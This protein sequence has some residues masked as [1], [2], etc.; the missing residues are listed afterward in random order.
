MKKHLLEIGCFFVFYDCLIFGY[1]VKYNV[2]WIMQNYNWKIKAINLNQIPLKDIFDEKNTYNMEKNVYFAPKKSD[3][4][5]EGTIQGIE[6]S[7]ERIN[8]AIKNGEKICVYADYDADG[9][10]SCAILLKT[11][12]CLGYKNITHYIPSRQTEGYGL[13]N[14]AVQKLSKDGVT[15]II[16]VDCGITSVQEIELANSLGVDVI[17]TDHHHCPEILPSAHCIINPHQKN[18]P[19]T[20]KNLC[21]AGI[22]YKLSDALLKKNGKETPNE[23]LELAGIATVTDIVELNGENRTIVKLALDFIKNGENIGVDALLKVAGIDRQSVNSR[24]IGFMIGPRINSAGRIAHADLALRLLIAENEQDALSFANELNQLNAKRQSFVEEVYND[25]VKKIN[26]EKAK[27][28]VIIT[29]SPEYH[30][31]VIGIAASKLVEKYGKIAV[32]L[33]EQSEIAVASL[34]SIEGFSIVDLLEHIRPITIKSGGHEMAGG[35]SVK[36]SDLSKIKDMIYKY[37]DKYYKTHNYKPTK[38]IDLITS[39]ENLTTENHDK[40]MRFEP[41]GA[42]NENFTLAVTDVNL[43]F[44]DFIGKDKNTFCA[45]LDDTNIKVI[46]FLAFEELK[47]LDTGKKLD[48]AF[49][50]NKNTFNNN[51][52]L[53]LMLEDVKYSEEVLQKDTEAFYKDVDT[54]L[55]NTA[56]IKKLIQEANEEDVK[57][58]AF[59]D[60]FLLQGK[61]AIFTCYFGEYKFIKKSLYLQ[62]IDKEK[63]EV[64]FLPFPIDLEEYENVVFCKYALSKIHFEDSQKLYKIKSGDFDVYKKRN[65]LRDNMKKIYSL[66]KKFGELDIKNVISNYKIELDELFA[67][68]KILKQCKL[69]DISYSKSYNIAVGKILSVNGKVDLQTV[70][71]YNIYENYFDNEI[72]G[73]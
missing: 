41:F 70:D 30:A 3:L 19:S 17:I 55:K 63:A 24:T 58:I 51:T 4:G 46:K 25:S 42:E 45:K 38:T 15:L 22:A 62:G 27:S 53:Q 16:T 21:G 23:L 56:Y 35:F 59:S 64:F 11:F 43:K 13:N 66:Y 44:A 68:N 20:F 26:E 37:V 1:S 18:C 7:V 61:T 14:D 36:L 71:I 57:Y 2:R 28:K 67:I 40:I 32:V 34:R 60:I 29:H 65:N 5:S 9:T 31:G 10:C 49:S 8:T 47:N 54:K 52:S 39:A 72:T 48:I 73:S 33:S 12:D 50:M 69:I 6:Q